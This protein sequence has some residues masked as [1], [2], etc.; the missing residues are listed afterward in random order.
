[1]Y[2]QDLC[3]KLIVYGHLKNLYY[4][5]NLQVDQQGQNFGPGRSYD[6]FIDFERDVDQAWN[7]S[8]PVGPLAPPPQAVTFH[9]GDAVLFLNAL[10]DFQRK[11]RRTGDTQSQ[12]AG[13]FVD[14]QRVLPV[15]SSIF[16]SETSD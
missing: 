14:V 6:E 12:V 15:L 16:S 11:R 3:K 5:A 13:D 10:D 8:K 9:D 4:C 2:H 1:M 7:K